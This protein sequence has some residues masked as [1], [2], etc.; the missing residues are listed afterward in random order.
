MGRE[1]RMVPPD[2][3]HPRYTVDNAPF[4][5]AVG[6]YIPAFDRD[7]EASYEEWRDEDVP[8][9][10]EGRSLWLEEGVVVGYSGRYRK[11]I[12]EVVAKEAQRG[13]VPEN[14]TYEWWAGEHP[15]AP[16]S[17]GYMPQ[18]PAEQRT[19]Y[20]MYEDTSEG[21]PISPAFATPHELAKWL[22][23]TGAS[24]FGSQTAS[25][26]EWLAITMGRPSLGLLISQ[27]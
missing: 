3:Q 20:M 4:P 24:V 27:S 8:R 22:A 2:W 17:S 16:R 15:A 12:A 25:Y 19:H 5:R 14:P 11:T 6:R 26:E 18:W 10:L 13:P 7:Y 21:T 1:V 9:W 23:E